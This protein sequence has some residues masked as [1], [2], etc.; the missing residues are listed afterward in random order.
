MM[1][2]AGDK[3][4]ADGDGSYDKQNDFARVVE[5][6]EETFILKR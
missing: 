5:S 1:D 2:D 6:N 3:D 4:A